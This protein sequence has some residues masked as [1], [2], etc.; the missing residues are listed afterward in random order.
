MV[1]K[2]RLLL[3][4]AFALLTTGACS[5][6]RSPQSEVAKAEL[7]NLQ[8]TWR[9]DSS[10]WNG[11]RDP[12][13][14]RSMTIVCQ[15]DKLIFFDKDGIRHEE[16]RIKLMPEQNPKAIDFWGKSD[17]PPSPGIYSLEGDT[18]T[19]CSAGGNNKVRPTSF[20]SA[21]GSKVSLMVLHR[22]RR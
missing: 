10:V 15:D 9:V 8:G 5:G 14:V 16:D 1:M 18:F 19:W 13:V 3:F 2:S 12:D 20:G 21:P 4:V 22:E 6:P 17:D 11:V 7:D